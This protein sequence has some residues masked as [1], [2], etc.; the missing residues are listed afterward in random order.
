MA[1]TF[2]RYDYVTSVGEVIPCE[3]GVFDDGTHYD[4]SFPDDELESSGS[5]HAMG[6]VWWEIIE[7]VLK[8]ED[9]RPIVRFADQDIVEAEIQEFECY[10]AMLGTQTP[11]W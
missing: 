2:K 4:V 3:C 9:A 6:T 5:T 1:T 8:S 10:A 11:D 7:R